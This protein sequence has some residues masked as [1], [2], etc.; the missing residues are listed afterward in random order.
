MRP[1]LGR[2]LATLCSAAAAGVLL[3]APAASARPVPGQSNWL[4]VTTGA[5][6]VAADG[7]R[8]STLALSP[9]AVVA[10]PLDRLG[11]KDRDG[12]DEPHL[13]VFT[14][15]SAKVLGRTI[16]DGRAC[17]L[18]DTAV[19][20]MAAALAANP[21]ATRVEHGQLGGLDAEGDAYL[22]RLGD[23]VW[24]RVRAVSGTVWYYLDADHPWLHGQVTV[25]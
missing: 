14:S 13:W 24:V 16:D 25:T 3:A 20:E 4:S 1:R 17:P 10:K 8:S 12:I 2:T 15:D 9:P 19:A 11:W 18:C 22:L 6:T 7:T 23:D 5:V 21:A